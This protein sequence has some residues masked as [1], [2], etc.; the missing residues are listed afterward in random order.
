MLLLS[1]GNIFFR[2]ANDLLKALECNSLRAGD[3]M[4]KGRR[5]G[6]SRFSL[7][8]MNSPDLMVYSF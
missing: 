3:E 1:L 7:S 6:E 2:S 8:S 4:Q 5:A